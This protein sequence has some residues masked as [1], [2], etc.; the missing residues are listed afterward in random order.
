MTATRKVL[1]LAVAILVGALVGF[2]TAFAL[3]F[4]YPQPLGVWAHPFV[5]AAAGA[6]IGAVIVLWRVRRRP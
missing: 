1:W 5:W 6:V 4:T 3:F 2:G